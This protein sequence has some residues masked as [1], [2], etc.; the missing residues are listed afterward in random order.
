MDS[1]EG[2]LSLSVESK[3]NNRS[4]ETSKNERLFNAEG[5]EFAI[6]LKTK[7]KILN[8]KNDASRASFLELSKALF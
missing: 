6:I 2:M 1:S 4:L 8:I 5:A 7:N 3:A